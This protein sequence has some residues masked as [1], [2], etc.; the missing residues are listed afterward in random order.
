MDNSNPNAWF[1]R[2]SVNPQLTPQLLSLY[3][4]GIGMDINAP[5]YKHVIVHPQ[6]SSPLTWVTAYHDSMYGRIETAWT[7][8][9]SAVTLKVKIP[10]NSTAT[11]YVPASNAAGVTESGKPASKSEGVT[12]V[13]M[14]NGSAVYEVAA[15]SYTF[16][17]KM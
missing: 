14:E 8:E 4:A 6:T 3:A 11:V 17:A 9:A 2:G 15:G 10:A 13:K 12:F 16:K 7:R 5:G 1:A